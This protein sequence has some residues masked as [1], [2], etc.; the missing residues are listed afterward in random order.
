MKVVVLERK[1]KRK[2]KER[3]RKVD[4]QEEEGERAWKMDWGEEKGMVG[5]L[6]FFFL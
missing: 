3:M 1:P 2:S 4:I 6:Q 5:A